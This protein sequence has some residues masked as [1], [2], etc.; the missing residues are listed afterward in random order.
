M[1]KHKVKALDILSACNLPELWII[2]MPE[3]LKPKSTITLDRRYM[4]LTIK[5][6]ARSSVDNKYE[7]LIINKKLKIRVDIGKDD[8]NKILFIN[9]L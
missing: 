8:K 6:A 7:I 2:L 1:L 3:I 4:L 5:K 9:V